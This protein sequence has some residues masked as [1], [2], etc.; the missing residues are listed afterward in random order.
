MKTCPKCGVTKP[1]S[2]FYARKRPNGTL[3]YGGYCKVCKRDIQR[4]WAR[5]PENRAKAAARKRAR[6]QRENQDPEA[7][8]RRR[9]RDREAKRRWR[10]ANPGRAAANTRRWRDGL[11]SDPERYATHLSQRRI[12]KRIRAERVTGK[13]EGGWIEADAMDAHRPPSLKDAIPAEPFV[14]WIRDEFH[15]AEPSTIA[16]ALH[17]PDRRVRALLNG[18]LDRVTLDFVDRA[19]TRGLGRPDLLNMVYPI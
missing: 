12:D 14:A 8:A 13:I 6:Y 16:I 17:I 10:A 3:R 1:E 5:L 15:G 11:Q 4:V 9:K 19:F 18:E 7:V 2:E